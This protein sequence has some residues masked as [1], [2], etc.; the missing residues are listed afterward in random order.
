MNY[1]IIQN[2]RHDKQKGGSGAGGAKVLL[3]DARLREIAKQMGLDAKDFGE[4]AQSMWQLLDDMATNDPKAYQNFIHEQLKD[5]PPVA[6]PTSASHDQSTEQSNQDAHTTKKKNTRDGPSIALPRYFTPTP[7]FVVKCAMYHTIKCQQ[8]ET[9]LFLN[10][11]AH[12]MIDLPKNPNNGSEVPKDTRAVPST[13][14]LV[15]PLVV[16]KIR[17]IQDFAG[18]LCVAIDVVFHPWIMQRCE[19]DGNF[20]REVMKLAIEWVQHDASVR[21]VTPVGKFIKSRYKGGVAAGDEIVTAKFLVD[22][23]QH[24]SKADDGNQ[25]S[26]E[27]EDEKLTSHTMDTPSTLLKQINLTRKQE[28]ENGF[29]IAP[30]SEKRA[31]SSTFQP[32]ALAMPNPKP[33]I[34]RDQVTASDHPN[35]P[36]EVITTEAKKSLIQVLEPP[37]SAA[38]ASNSPATRSAAQKKKP[39]A[40]KPKSCAVKKGFLNSAKTQLYPTGSNEGKVSSPYVN[41]L[42]RSKVVDLADIERQKK[43]QEQQQRETQNEVLSFLNPSEKKSSASSSAEVDCGDFEFEQL[44]MEADPDLKPQG[45]QQSGEVD[46]AARQLFRNGLDEISKFLTL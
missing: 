45:Q 10:C 26:A 25:K 40:T 39:T 7:G 16:G 17:E 37:S 38:S 1:G 44:C 35:Q 42:S 14:N 19:W 30:V 18:G 32:A 33:H 23:S 13:S 12:E 31:S 4:E 8:Q 11:C 27:A 34:L 24:S 46:D 3:Q 29:L 28:D 9:K 43:Q 20:K 15:I 2:R 5:G 36:R 21:L 22:P 6:P 41:L